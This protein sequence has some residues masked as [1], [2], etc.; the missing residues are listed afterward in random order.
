MFDDIVGRRVWRNVLNPIK[1]LGNR[2]RRFLD[3]VMGTVLIYIYIY[4]YICSSYYYM[5]NYF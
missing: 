3:S 2:I 5:I 1:Y 4:I